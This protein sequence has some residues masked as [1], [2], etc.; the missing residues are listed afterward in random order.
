MPRYLAGPG[1]ADFQ[2]AWPFPFEE[3]WSLH[4]PDEGHRIASSPC[5]RV[6]T[7]FLPNLGSPSRGTWTTTAQKPF[8]QPEWRATFTGATPL[9]V[10]RDF[11]T[12]LLSL[13]LEDYL[14]DDSTPAVEGYLSLLAEG[15]SHSVWR[16]GKQEF[17]SK[18]NLAVLR[19]WYAGA[20][21]GSWA[22]HAGFPDRPSE[23][24]VWKATFT[25]GTPV[26]LISALTSSLV[27][28]QPLTRAVR[29]L[30]IL[31]RD[32]LYFPQGL[33]ARVTPAKPE[34]QP[35]PATPP[36]APRSGRSR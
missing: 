17:C 19:H 30:P 22:F 14:L 18:D 3:G 6:Q 27:K 23:R 16:E 25:A 13:Y 29:D 5:L 15:W 12:E 36:P 28:D 34:P 33:P 21:Q 10:L 11:H 24:F 32:F 2:S 20:A 9:E 31:T 8:G 35:Q 26:P 4:R 7:G 1:S